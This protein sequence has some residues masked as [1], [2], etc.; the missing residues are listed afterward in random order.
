[1]IAN[2]PAQYDSSHLLQHAL[3]SVAESARSLWRSLTRAIAPRSTASRSPSTEFG[4]AAR[5]EE[6]L[7]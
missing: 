6:D 3:G 5:V 7:T 1:M 4:C 2:P